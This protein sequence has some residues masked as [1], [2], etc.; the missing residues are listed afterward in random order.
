MYDIIMKLVKLFT[1]SV[2]VLLQLILSL[3][4]VAPLVVLVSTL[5]LVLF[6][7]WAPVAIVIAVIKLTVTGG[8]CHN[9]DINLFTH[10]ESND[11]K[12]G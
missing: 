9:I 11:A 12:D 8:L 1:T 3:F 7:L 10:K 5:T 2:A 4:V 6:I